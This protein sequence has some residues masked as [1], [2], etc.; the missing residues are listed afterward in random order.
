MNSDGD[1]DNEAVNMKRLE[2]VESSLVIKV[3]CPDAG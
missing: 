1:F 3:S 2:F